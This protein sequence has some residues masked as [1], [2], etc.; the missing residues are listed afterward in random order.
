[1]ENKQRKTIKFEGEEIFIEVSQYDV[2]DRIA[3]LAYTNKESY[4]N[5]TINLPKINIKNDEGFIAPIAKNCGI[6]EKLIKE[7]IIKKINKTIMYNMEKYDLVKFD[8][9]ELRK[10]DSKGIE[11]FNLMLKEKEY[12]YEM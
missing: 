8:L 5:I 9:E 3:L 12:N 4:S 2:N 1:M 6:V 10:Y 7:K 11:K